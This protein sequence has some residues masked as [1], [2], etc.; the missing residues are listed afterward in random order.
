MNNAVIVAGIDAV[1]IT[2]PEASTVERDAAL[3]A[4]KVV[5]TVADP[6]T[7]DVAHDALVALVK[8]CKEVEASRLSVTRPIDA[9]KKR[10]METAAKFTD[11][12]EREVLRLKGLLTEYQRKLDAEAKAEAKRQEEAQKAEEERL[13]KASEAQEAAAQPG[14][15]ASTPEPTVAPAPATTLATT[16][17]PTPA[18]AKPQTLF[19]APTLQAPAKLAGSMTRRPWK[20]KVEDM[21]KLFA[22]RPDL[23]RLEEVPSLVNSA[24]AGGLR[25]CPGL[26]IYQDVQVGVRV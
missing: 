4:S 23:C 19:V 22:A 21:G 16:P 3:A 20:Y 7:R 24:I 10:V 26:T 12:A 9:L 11:E 15:P 14:A 6:I 17:A 1:S 8:I 2:I 25:E 13:R 18:P 5:G